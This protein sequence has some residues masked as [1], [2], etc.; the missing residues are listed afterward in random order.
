MTSSLGLLGPV[1]CS[2]RPSVGICAEGL[3]NVYATFKNTIV[4]EVSGSSVACTGVE[5][6]YAVIVVLQPWGKR[7]HLLSL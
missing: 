5:V 2:P 7:K 6:S 4:M 3:V 1:S